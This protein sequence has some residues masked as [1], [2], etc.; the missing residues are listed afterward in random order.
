MAALLFL[1]LSDALWFAVC[2][3]KTCYESSLS[4]SMDAHKDVTDPQGVLEGDVFTTWHR[5]GHFLHLPQVD[6]RSVSIT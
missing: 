5:P 2:H 1:L 3:K 6:Q 4:I